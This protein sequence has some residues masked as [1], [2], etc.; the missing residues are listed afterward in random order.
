MTL[1]Q[2]A[3]STLVGDTSSAPNEPWRVRSTSPHR[4]GRQPLDFTTSAPQ[5]S[6]V[7]TYLVCS[8][9]SRPPSYAKSVAKNLQG[10]LFLTP[11]CRLGCGVLMV[12]AT[13]SLR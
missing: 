11:V 5:R 13:V 8:P 12:G 4:T 2:R 7:H 10:G 9:N 1:K 3:Q 6:H